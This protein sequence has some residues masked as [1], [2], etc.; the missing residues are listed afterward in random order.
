MNFENICRQMNNLMFTLQE[1]KWQN[2]L[3]FMQPNLLFENMTETGLPVRC[4][5]TSI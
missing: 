1:R 3:T 5:S 4:V 2:N